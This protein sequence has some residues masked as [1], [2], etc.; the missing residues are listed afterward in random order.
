M[1]CHRDESQKSISACFPQPLQSVAT[2]FGYASY[3]ANLHVD[4][5]INNAHFSK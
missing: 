3:S 2:T 1:S 4:S 5:L